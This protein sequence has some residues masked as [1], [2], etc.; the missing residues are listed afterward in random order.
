MTGAVAGSVPPADDAHASKKL[1][2][3]WRMQLQTEKLLIAHPDWKC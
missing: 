3:L 2:F 1:G